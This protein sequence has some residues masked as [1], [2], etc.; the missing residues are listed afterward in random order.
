MI[1]NCTDKCS[2]DEFETTPCSTTT[3]R[4]CTSCT[5]SCTEGTYETV[6]CTE[7]TNRECEDC[8]DGSYCTGGENISICS[9]PCAPGTYET[10]SCNT[11]TN[12]ICNACPSEFYCSGNASIESCKA[13]CATGTYESTPCTNTTDRECSACPNNSYC[14]GGKAVN[15]CGCAPG[16]CETSPCTPFSN[17]VC[18]QCPVLVRESLAISNLT[19]S[20]CTC[21]S[22]N[23]VAELSAIYKTQ[24]LPIACESG[25]STIQ[26]VNFKCP[27]SAARRL[28]AT[29]STKFIVV[30]QSAPKTTD[31]EI[32]SRAIQRVLPGAQVMEKTTTLLEQKILAWDNALVTYAPSAGWVPIA[33]LLGLAAFCVFYFLA[34]VGCS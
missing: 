24:V 4:V 5:T 29:E 25:G 16:L 28:L 18:G 26:C 7:T 8:P 3:N 9:E 34:F 2:W 33:A 14:P 27:C 1:S 22:T 20:T 23:L 31:T 12:R 17:T 11:T 32:I 15:A 6:P 13:P 10:S 21:T 30:Y 19:I